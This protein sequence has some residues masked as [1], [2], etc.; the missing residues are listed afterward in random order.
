M[1]AGRLDIDEYGDRTARVAA[2]KTR[3]ELAALFHDLPEP[4]PT[5]T[6]QAKAAAPQ[7]PNPPLAPPSAVAQ[8]WH[9]RPLGQRLY[10]GLVPLSFILASVMFFFVTRGAW[11]V[12]LIPVAITI[13]GG[14]L[15]GEDWSHDR[16]A[17]QREQRQRRRRHWD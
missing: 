8:R 6:P 9:D 10:S 16:R 4:R 11:V 13:I 1:S 17:Y 15:F 3:G 12:F 2:S 14:S 7:V 5:F